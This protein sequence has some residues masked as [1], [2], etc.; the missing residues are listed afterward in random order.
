[1]TEKLL[2]GKYRFFG[3]ERLIGFDNSCEN[4]VSLGIC[5]IFFNFIGANMTAFHRDTLFSGFV[6]LAFVS[7]GSIR[8]AR[9]LACSLLD[10]LW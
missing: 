10:L 3:I 6:A 2:A 9:I 5:F 8:L 4:L 1:M 7:L